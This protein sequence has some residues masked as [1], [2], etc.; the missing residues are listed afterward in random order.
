MWSEI[1]AGAYYTLTFLS[2]SLFLSA[3]DAMAGQALPLHRPACE[4]IIKSP[5]IDFKISI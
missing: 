2:V 5:S 3:C 1:K 4:N